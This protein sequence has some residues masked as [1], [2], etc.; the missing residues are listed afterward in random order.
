M[1]T[2]DTVM[3][4]P[5]SIDIRDDGDWSAA[6]R[7]AFESMHEAD[8]RFS[9]FRAESEVSAVNRGDIVPDE[10]SADLREVL[11]IGRAIEAASAEA[12]TLRAPDGTLD[13]DGIVK[14]WAAARAAAALRRA[15]IRT[16]CLNAGGDVAVAGTPDG[17]PW[18]I[19]IRSPS[20]AHRMLAVLSVTD[21]AIATSGAYERGA[22]II[23]GRTGMPATAYASVTVIA[24]DLTVADALA[25]AVFALGSDGVGWALGQ[26]ARGVLAL[27][28][29]GE[30]VGA[31]ELPFAHSLTD[32]RHPVSP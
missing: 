9:R 16:F 11:D 25:T 32:G 22:H 23:D 14:G 31:G 26:G 3:G 4:I 27:N 30:L 19:G 21:G 28:S 7:A 5:M 12:F 17:S 20:D 15:G 18:N 8:R 24:D 6:A 10:F 2:L 1:R 13:T 29:D